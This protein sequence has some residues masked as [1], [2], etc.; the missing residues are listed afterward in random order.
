ML[1]AIAEGR[2][3]K[4][5]GLRER[6]R[7][8]PRAPIRLI[9][10]HLAKDVNQ[11]GLLRL[12]EAFRLEGVD[13]EPADTA[14]CDLRGAVGGKSWQPH[15]W[16][17]PVEAIAEARGRGFR[18]VALSVQEGSVALERMQWTF[19][20]ALVVGCEDIGVPTELRGLC[21]ESV[22]IPMYG[23]VDSLNVAVST[24]IVVHRMVM[25]YRKT[26]PEFV[27]AREASRRLVE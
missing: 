8:L 6:F 3:P 22:A 23:M 14:E 4:D 9:A 20:T 26:H 12:A 21:D 15:R 27:P 19:P 18:I 1:A 2:L 13:F 16:I 17:E 11:G 5:P 10:P 7:S 24:G 25:A